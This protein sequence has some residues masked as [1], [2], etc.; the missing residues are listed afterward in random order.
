[1]ADTRSTPLPLPGLGEPG[2]PR[3]DRLFYLEGFTRRFLRRQGKPVR[4]RGEPIEIEDATDVTGCLPLLLLHMGVIL[5]R[6]QSRAW[7]LWFSGLVIRPAEGAERDVSLTGM[8]VID[9][10][11]YANVVPWLFLA[12]E[13]WNQALTPDQRVYDVDRW[14]LSADIVPPWVR[15][16]DGHLP[17]VG[18]GFDRDMQTIR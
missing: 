15:P 3:L 13:S 10:Q 9:T 16:A 6:A 11:P 18:P 12:L 14:R 1:M 17:G 7:D 5:E 4:W 8:T 2:L